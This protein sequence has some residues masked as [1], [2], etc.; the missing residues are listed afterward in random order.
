MG[1]SPWTLQE[2]DMT[3]QLHFHFLPLLTT[4]QSTEVDRVCYEGREPRRP[5]FFSASLLS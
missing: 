5:D 1:Y 2:S 4:W 3:E